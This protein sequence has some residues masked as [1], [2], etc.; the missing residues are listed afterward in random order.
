MPRPAIF[1]GTFHLLGLRIIREN[2]GKDFTLLSRDE[3]TE[4]LKGLMKGTSK[5][6]QQT[7]EGYFPD[8][9]RSQIDKASGRY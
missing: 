7:L 8:K 6:I 1:I 2:I 4:L 9:E 5:A 3:Q